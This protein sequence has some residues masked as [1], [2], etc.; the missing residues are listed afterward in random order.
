MRVT[1]ESHL[2]LLSW[3]PWNCS[4]QNLSDFGHRIIQPKLC[5][6]KIRIIHELCN[7][8]VLSQDIKFCFCGPRC[9]FSYLCLYHEL[10]VLARTISDVCNIYFELCELCTY[11]MYLL[12][13]FL[14][15]FDGKELLSLFKLIGT[16]LGDK[17]K[18]EIQ[19]TLIT[20]ISVYIIGWWSLQHLLW[21][22]RI[23]GDKK[24]GDLQR[25]RRLL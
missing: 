20:Y 9:H 6:D 16:R 10:I 23:L 1:A 24:A 7:A 15:V 12:R 14:F 4:L 5:L 11:L 19:E 18:N 2:L 13:T 22:D 25:I 21:K 3:F 17:K 8:K